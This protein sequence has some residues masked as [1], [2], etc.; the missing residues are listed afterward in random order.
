MSHL[1][2]HKGI[3][4]FD[5]SLVHL[6]KAEDSCA[7]NLAPPAELTEEE[8]ELK[9]EFPDLL[10]KRTRGMPLARSIIHEVT[11]FAGLHDHET[12]NK[13][14]ELKLSRE[15]AGLH[16]VKFTREVGARGAQAIAENAG[17]TLVLCT[18]PGMGGVEWL[19]EVMAA[20][21]K[22]WSGKKSNRLHQSIADLMQHKSVLAECAVIHFFFTTLL[23]PYRTLSD[24][25]LPHRA[26]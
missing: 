6:A 16:T 5:H 14:V 18:T 15:A 23:S 26:R 1:C 11:K 8:E 13:T 10:G 20:K 21:S 24:G 22:K 19:M 3:N 12:L 9:E 2:R 25:R 7:F 17:S 4:F